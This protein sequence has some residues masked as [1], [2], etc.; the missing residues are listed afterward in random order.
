MATV[1]SLVVQDMEAATARGPASFAGVRG[2]AASTAAAAARKP[3]RKAAL[4]GM[5]SGKA[6]AASVL[7][8]DCDDRS[9]A[10]AAASLSRLLGAST[11]SG[12]KRQKAASSYAATPLFKKQLVP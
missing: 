6:T 12:Q 7:G 10:R 3:K 8:A 11:R 2:M 1:D 4:L 5:L 9:S